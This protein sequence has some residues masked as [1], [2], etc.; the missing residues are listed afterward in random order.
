MRFERDYRIR[1][2]HC[3]P[4]GIVFFPQY[5]VLFNQLVEDW[6]TDGLGI[7]YTE[8][9]GPR[10][11]GLPI[12]RLECDFRAIG[13]MGE[14]LSFSLA[15]ERVGGKS[16]TLALEASGNGV[17]RVASRQVLVFTDLDTHRAI[18]LP[19]DVRAALANSAS[20]A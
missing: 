8:M 19:E 4:A 18:S 16:L 11:I 9:L 20:V 2:S 17:L 6:F 13:R 1:F 3:D 7:S 15:V 14:T 5:L 10:R 12:V